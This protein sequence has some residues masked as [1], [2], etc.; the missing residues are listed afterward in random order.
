MAERQKMG[1][2]TRIRIFRKMLDK[3][4]QEENTAAAMDRGFDGSGECGKFIDD[5]MYKRLKEKCKYLLNTLTL[6]R[7][8]VQ[9]ILKHWMTIEAQ[10]EP[11]AAPWDIGPPP[12]YYTLSLFEQLMFG[13]EN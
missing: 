10:H 4:W 7:N 3:Y 9:V 6:Q 13:E 2:K 11:E 8:H 12:A 1:L 5:V